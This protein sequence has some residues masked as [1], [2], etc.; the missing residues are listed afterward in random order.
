MRIVL[1]GGAGFIGHAT[2][3]RLHADGHELVVISRT[4]SKRAP[5]NTE[6]ID[7]DATAIDPAWLRGAAAVLNLVGIKMPQ[8]DNNFTRAHQR[9]VAAMLAAT[10]TAGVHRFVHVGVVSPPG[11]SGPYHESKRSGE[12]LVRD[13]GLDWTILRPSVVYGAGDDMLTH[14]VEQL[15]V[16]AVFPIPGGEL[17]PLQPIDVGDVAE[18]IARALARPE[19][20]GR[21][22]DLVGPE[23]LDVRDLVRRVAHALE[24]P[25]ATPTIPSAIMR[26]LAGLAERWLTNPPVTR[27]QLEML[28]TGLPGD[29]EPA[30]RELELRPRRLTDAR[31]VELAARVPTR[32]PSTRLVT[33]AEH[34]AWL[35]RTGAIA[36]WPLV[37]AVSIAMLVMPRW[38][39]SIWPRMALVEG[40]TTIAAVALL[41]LP[42]RELLRVRVPAVVGGLLGA[43]V[44]WCAGALAIALLG[45]LA[46]ALLAELPTI[47]AFTT[48]LPSSLAIVAMLAIVVAEDI[49]WRGVVTLRAVASFGAVRGCV[50]AGTLFAIAHVTSGPPLLWLA[51]LGCGTLWSAVAVRTRSLVP[52]IVMHAGW[53]TLVMFV[54]RYD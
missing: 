2:A 21:A 14:L 26:P 40:I 39:P 44:L 29:R 6:A 18:A 24:L 3:A 46:P 25:T 7:G 13:S 41:R 1:I 11:A 30:A 37:A 45:S 8:G 19:S 20:I 53:D 43:L 49:V 36:A 34:R 42:W 17:G 16:A 23:L 31:I 47:Y 4:A 28:R 33:S 52:V 50:A 10:I 48:E 32:L 51:A 38:V 9:A 5:A 15:R 54:W 22:Y 27:S 12:A 35:A